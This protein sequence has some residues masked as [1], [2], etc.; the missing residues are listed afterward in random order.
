VNMLT[1][2]KMTAFRDIG[3]CSYKLIDVSEVF[4]ASII[5]AMI[6]GQIRDYTAQ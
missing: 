2:M 4:T 6:A 3:P 5:R 1:G